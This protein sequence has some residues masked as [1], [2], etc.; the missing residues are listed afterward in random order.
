MY[1]KIN[2]SSQWL[3]RLKETLVISKLHKCPSGLS[4]L[5]KTYLAYV[6]K[7]VPFVYVYNIYNT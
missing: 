2:L 1:I 4:H 6:P 7:K 3:N 5:R